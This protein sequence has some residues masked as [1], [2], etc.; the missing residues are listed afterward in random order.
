[1][2]AAAE[3]PEQLGV[4]VVARAY[5]FARGND[6]LG[7]DQVVSSE[8]VLG[9]EAADAAAEGKA[10]DSGGADHAPGVT[11]PCACVA[12]SKS[13]QVSPPSEMAMRASGST[14]TFPHP[15]QVDHQ[16]VVSGAV[17]GT[18]VV[19]AADGDLQAVDSAK[20]SEVATSTAST[21]RATTAGRRSI[22]RLKQSRARSCSRSDGPSASPV[23]DSRSCLTLLVHLLLLGSC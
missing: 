6:Q 9:G 21:Q 5:H 12:A 3:P 8:S 22:S 23:S 1:L 11:R 15:R 18:F 13:S 17:P 14:S 16:A 7:G 10:G 20:A 19:A 2:P 4:L